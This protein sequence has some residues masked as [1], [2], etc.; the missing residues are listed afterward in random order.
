MTPN[1]PVNADARGSVVH[2]KGSLA[3]AGYWERS[4]AEVTGSFREAIY[5]PILSLHRNQL[6]IISALQSATRIL[7]MTDHLTIVGGLGRFLAGQSERVGDVDVLIDTEFCKR[8]WD[9]IEILSLHGITSFFDVI[10]R[11]NFPWD[12]CCP[13]IAHARALTVDC[14]ANMRGLKHANLDVC[15]KASD[16]S[17]IPRSSQ[18]VRLLNPDELRKL[19]ESARTKKISDNHQELVKELTAAETTLPNRRSHDELGLYFAW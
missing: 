13:G 16:L 18:W 19:D 5:M 4:A 1:R 15:F 12:Y 11:P 8:Y 7:Q 2:C 17:A 10:E 9:L 6:R 3:R 14:C